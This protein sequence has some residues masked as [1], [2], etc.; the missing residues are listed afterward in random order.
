MYCIFYM[1][2]DKKE[3]KTMWS[4]LMSCS[5]AQTPDKT[6]LTFP[7]GSWIS[8]ILPSPNW[9]GANIGEGVASKRCWEQNLESFVVKLLILYHKD[10]DVIS[11]WCYPHH[12]IP[13][14]MLL[15]SSRP[16][17]VVAVVLIVLC[18]A[19]PNS[20][21]FNSSLMLQISPNNLIFMALN[22]SKAQCCTAL[23][24]F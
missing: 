7:N 13:F 18:V 12:P 22:S 6:N 15:L 3:I 10:Y 23:S 4:L 5:L 1:L 11:S 16:F 14:Q 8:K 24:C 17:V 21:R 9:G 19:F 2:T 20:I